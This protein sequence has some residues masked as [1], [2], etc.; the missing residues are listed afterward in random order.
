MTTL[1]N[2]QIIQQ[3]GKPAFVVIPY[4]EYMATFGDLEQHKANPDNTVPHEVMR[5]V[6]RED[7]TLARAWR[8]YLGLTQEEVANRMGITQSALAQMETVS[9]PRKA[10]RQKLAKALGINIEQLI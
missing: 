6:L 9:K 5:Y 10:T 4:D 8:E 1:T 7:Y 3:G 2:V